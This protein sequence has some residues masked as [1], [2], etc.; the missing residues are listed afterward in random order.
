MI[1]QDFKTISGTIYLSLYWKLSSYMGTHLTVEE[2]W[3]FYFVCVPKYLQRQG[4]VPGL[5]DR[6]S[7]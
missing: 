3:L 1:S 4:A 5:R 7:G 6:R 2:L